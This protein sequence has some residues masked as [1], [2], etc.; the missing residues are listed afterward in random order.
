MINEQIQGPTCAKCGLAEG[1]RNTPSFTAY[2]WD[3][4]GLNPNR[5]VPLCPECA[6]ENEEYWKAMWQEYYYAVR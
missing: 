4:T 5:D 1:V 6:I 2:Y 3:G